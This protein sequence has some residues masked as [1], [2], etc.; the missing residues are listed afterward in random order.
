M[1]FLHR[2]SECPEMSN[3]PGPG[4]PPELFTAALVVGGMQKIATFVLSAGPASPTRTIGS[5]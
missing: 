4:R 5:E 3:V 2:M 1:S